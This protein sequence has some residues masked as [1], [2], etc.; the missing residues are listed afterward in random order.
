MIVLSAASNIVSNAVEVNH[1]Q[2]L[3]KNDV[4][5]ETTFLTHY[6][7]LAFG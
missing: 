5:A 7:E 6:S 1:L 3:V 4:Y 2:L